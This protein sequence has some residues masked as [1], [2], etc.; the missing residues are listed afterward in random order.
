MSSVNEIPQAQMADY[1]DFVALVTNVLLFKLG[2][3]ITI[4]IAQ[5]G[6]IAKEYPRIRIAMRATDEV[7]PNTEASVTL[8]LISA[9]KRKDQQGG[10]CG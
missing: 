9:E 5:L 10:I 4:P 6:E 2:G 3:Q 1:P 7:I 8:T